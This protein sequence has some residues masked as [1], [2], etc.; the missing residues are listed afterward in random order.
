MDKLTLIDKRASLW[1]EMKTFLD[2]HTGADGKISAED[3][4]TY[5]K[6]EAD[7]LALDRNIKRYSDR[8]T[9][10]A[11]MAAPTSQPILNNPKTSAM[12]TG[13]ASDEYRQAALTALRTNF[14][15]EHA[16]GERIC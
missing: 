10:E 13:R 3:A 1:Q 16:A 12:K 5:D 7:I 9:R 6:M 11:E 15:D 2:E 14:R 8:E 4:A